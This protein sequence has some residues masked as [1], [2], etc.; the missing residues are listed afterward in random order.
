M[1][2]LSRNQKK[3]LGRIYYVNNGFTAKDAAEKVEVSETTFSK[4]VNEFGW[5]SLKA[6][7]IGKSDNLISALEDD[8][9]RIREHA[10]SEERPINAQ[11]A[12][13]IYKTTLSIRNLGKDFGID[14]YNAVLQEFLSYSREVNPE[15]QKQGVDI[16][17]SFLTQKLKQRGN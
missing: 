14:I 17:D 1:K 9:I 5:K 12:D 6:A 13:S 7:E 11:E 2:G 8:I 4:W 3:E 15:F 16:C 10:L